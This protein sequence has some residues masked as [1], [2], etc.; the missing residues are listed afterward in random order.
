MKRLPYPKPKWLTRKH[1]A[2][3]E[4]G[5]IPVHFHAVRPLKAA[6]VRLRRH[7][8]PL[9][10]PHVVSDARQPAV[11]APVD[12]ADAFVAPP[13]RQAWVRVVVVQPRRHYAP[14]ARVTRKPD[15]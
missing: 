1:L 7:S 6:A 14:T 15:V 13:Y 2:K 9:S 3:K 4:A 5:R 8:A 12:A 11:P 10:E